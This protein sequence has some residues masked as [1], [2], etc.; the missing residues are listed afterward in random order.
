MLHFSFKYKWCIY[1]NFDIWLLSCE[2]FPMLMGSV[3][4]ISLRKSN[5]CYSNLTFDMTFK[6]LES[7]NSDSIFNSFYFPHTFSFIFVLYIPTLPFLPWSVTRTVYLC[8]CMWGVR[9][10]STAV[11][12]QQ[13]QRRENESEE[14][15]EIC[16]RI[17]IKKCHFDT[18]QLVF[19]WTF[20]PLLLM[21]HISLFFVSANKNKQ[22]RDKISAKCQSLL[23]T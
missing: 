7:K 19:K 9:K 12:R 1:S 5:G 2:Q 22:S 8:M 10:V 21:G 11:E 17:A 14:E 4:S 3:S 15:L 13:Q 6:S 18:C 23:K 16:N 20:P